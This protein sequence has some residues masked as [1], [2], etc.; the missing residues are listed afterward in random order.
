[1]IDSCYLCEIGKDGLM[2]PYDGQTILICA[3]CALA[4][5]LAHPRLNAPRHAAYSHL[6]EVVT[7]MT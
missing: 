7:E 6:N 4:A 5:I 1:M 2:V 3:E